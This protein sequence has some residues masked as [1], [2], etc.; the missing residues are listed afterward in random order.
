MRQAPNF[1]KKN[2]FLST[3]WYRRR[4]L[5]LFTALLISAQLTGQI[6]LLIFRADIIV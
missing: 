2:W 4:I 6:E 5:R 1:E 3:S